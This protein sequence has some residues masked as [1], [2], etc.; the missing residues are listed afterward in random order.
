[1]KK[2][3]HLTAGIIAGVVFLLIYNVSVFAHQ[4]N[5]IRNDTIRLH[6]IANSDSEEDQELKLKVRD[7]V[8]AA[9]QDIF[10]GSVTKENAE[11]KIT[12][13]L[14]ALEKAAN[15]TIRENGKSYTARAMLVTEYFDT[16]TYNDTVTL[17]AG[18]YLALKIVLGNGDGKNW[19]CV[20]FPSLCL[21]A[22]EKTD[23][24]AIKNVYSEKE[25]NIVTKSEK[26]EYRF[27][28]IEIIEKVRNKVDN[29]FQG[30]IA[31]H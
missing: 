4:C 21:P 18:K 30:D 29:Q 22:A 5:E 26:Y 10:D 28:I 27:K 1:M 25:E 16:R 19:W 31:Y 20:M 2:Y 8:L 14:K 23:I 7:A 3:S 17:P 6:V 11:A 13:Q 12:A 15:D 24:Q 9:G